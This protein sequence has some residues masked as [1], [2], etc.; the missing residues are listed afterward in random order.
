MAF[1][2]TIVIVG[3]ARIPT[4]KFRGYYANT[5][6]HE[7]GAAAARA[8]AERAGIPM[9]DVDDFVVGCVGQ[10]GA[11]A[12]ISRRIALT[13]GARASS[14]ALTV[15]RVC[16]SGVQALASGASALRSGDARIVMAGGAE[17][18]TRQPVMDFSRAGHLDGPE[19][20]DGTFSLISDPF[21]GR[22]MGWTAE[23]V[24][25]KFGISR[26]EQDAFAAQSQARAQAAI[27]SGAFDKEKVPF[28]IDAGKPTERVVVAEEYPR[29]G[30][31][32]ETLSHL[33]PVFAA[34][35]TVT[36]GNSSGINDGAAMLVLMRE[37]DAIAA[38]VDILGE[39]VDVA[40]VGVE[41]EYMGYAPRLAIEKVLERTGLS[42]ADIGWVEL[43]EAFASQAIAVIRDAEL[44]PEIV[45]PL[46]GAIALG[47]PVGAS[48]AIISLRALLNQRE[49]GIEHS[50]VTLC[51]GG[52]QGIAAIIRAR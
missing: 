33:S 43:N 13:A 23:R 16:G 20:V 50:L 17:S 7:L 37:E 42:R 19:H 32:A 14:T 29:T 4:G 9:A 26:A 28:T 1:D 21:S 39:L 38:G 24:A 10:T 27:T 3:G 18:M 40:T 11:D 35:G 25:E 15:N 12:Y 34:H 49:R 8:A 30:V 45:N 44:D 22:P 48:G 46:G 47:H 2:S 52:G 31:T 6:A 41:P 36:A 5:P 51:I